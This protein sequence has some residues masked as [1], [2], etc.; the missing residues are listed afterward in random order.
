LE[1]VPMTIPRFKYSLYAISLIRPERVG[2]VFFP[3]I[4]FYTI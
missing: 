1:E 4:L 2:K 3:T